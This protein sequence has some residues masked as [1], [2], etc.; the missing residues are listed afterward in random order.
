MVLNKLLFPPVEMKDKDVH[1]RDNDLGFFLRMLGINHLR[2]ITCMRAS[3]CMQVTGT[4]LCLYMD[5]PCMGRV[6][7]QNWSRRARLHNCDHG[8]PD[9]AYMPGEVGRRNWYV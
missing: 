2:R 7:G 1:P 6:L 8:W 3:R 9:V 5:L 4:N